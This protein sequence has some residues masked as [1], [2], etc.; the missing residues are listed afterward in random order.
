M[1]NAVLYNTARV[2]VKH[3]CTLLQCPKVFYLIISTEHYSG[4]YKY[5]EGLWITLY[6]IASNTSKHCS[7]RYQCLVASRFK[8]LHVTLFGMETLIT[9]TPNKRSL[10][11][12]SFIPYVDNDYSRNALVQT[13]AVEVTRAQ[14]W[15]L[16]TRI[17]FLF[18]SSSLLSSQSCN[19]TYQLDR[20]LRPKCQ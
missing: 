18:E 1:L 5:P 15:P 14:V 4:H 3:Y 11:K 10:C 6:K 2:T 7:G 20:P 19:F 12:S 8:T 17:Y 16:S 9:T 13:R